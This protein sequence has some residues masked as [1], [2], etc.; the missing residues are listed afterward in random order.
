MLSFR[1]CEHEST[2][3]HVLCKQSTPTLDILN[4]LLSI[5]KDTLDKQDIDGCTALHSI[6]KVR[7]EEKNKVYHSLQE[8]VA[9]LL[10]LSGS[11]VSIRNNEGDTAVH[12]AA[13]FESH[14]LMALFIQSDYYFPTVNA[15]GSTVLHIACYNNIGKV[16]LQE[17]RRF[18]YLSRCRRK[19]CFAHCLSGRKRS[20]G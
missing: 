17:R 10:L 18:S 6:V 12:F 3:L 5:S 2:L 13:K 20:V 8:D 7:E 19:H 15:T 4:Q 14:K 1:D 16:V 11:D 9:E